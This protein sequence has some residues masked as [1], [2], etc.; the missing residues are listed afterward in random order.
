LYDT[1]GNSPYSPLINTTASHAALPWPRNS[2]A[3]HA[4]S[5]SP[6]STIGEVCHLRR[7]RAHTSLVQ[8]GMSLNEA[9]ISN[10]V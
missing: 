4:P 9:R 3:R 2:K 6:A 5:L 1:G 8:R 7:T 10:E